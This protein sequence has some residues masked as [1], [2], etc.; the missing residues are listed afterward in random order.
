MIDGV[1]EGKSERAF[2]DVRW[3]TGAG[4]VTG[5]PGRDDDRHPC[6]PPIAAPA[7]NNASVYAFLRQ[8]LPYRRHFESWFHA[9]RATR[10]DPEM[11][12]T[13]CWPAS[14]RAGL[15]LMPRSSWKCRA[16]SRYPPGRWPDCPAD[17]VPTQHHCTAPAT[18]GVR[19]FS[20]CWH[21]AI[22]E[23]WRRSL[24]RCAIFENAIPPLQA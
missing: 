16:I 1:L 9:D 3:C 12:S 8:L 15:A 24:A 10:A 17:D 4:R 21:D 13:G 22:R 14:L 11:E 20:S 19:L 18:I 7:V 23:R 5:V 2:V 6:H